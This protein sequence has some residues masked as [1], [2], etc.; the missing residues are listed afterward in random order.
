MINIA[1]CEDNDLDRKIL[2]QY[3]Q[4]VMENKLKKGKIESYLIS[5][6]TNGTDIMND[7]EKH[8]YHLVFLDMYMGDMIGIE[9]AKKIRSLDGQTLIIFVTSSRDFAIE[10]YSVRAYH[11]L[12]KPIMKIQVID[13]IESAID[14]ILEK[15][16]RYL[17][18]PTLE[19][20]SKIKLQDLYY[21]ECVAR[22]TLIVMK[23]EKF[24]CT[25]NINTMEEKLNNMGFV[26]CHRSFI[27]N[28]NYISS[29]RTGSILMENDEEVLLS[30][31][32]QKEVRTKFTEYLGGQL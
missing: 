8:K 10:G 15:E 24:T 20:I 25:Y 12:L 1:I 3:L 14:H 30:K 18:L 2:E 29:L 28:L 22:K 32:R 13:T 21:I 7:L 23:D 27:I 19:G 9:I 6:Y 31:Y 26:R 5:T 17:L 16:D 11:Y 4:E